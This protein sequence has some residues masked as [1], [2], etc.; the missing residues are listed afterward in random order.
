MEKINPIKV[1]LK[2][3]ALSEE[4]SRIWANSLNIAQCMDLLNE[5]V[6]WIKKHERIMMKDRVWLLEKLAE[7]LEGEKELKRYSASSKNLKTENNHLK[8]EQP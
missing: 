1:N 4:A 8:E 7:I 5:T 3:K 2:N 6:G